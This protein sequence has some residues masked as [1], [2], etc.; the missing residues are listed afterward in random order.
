M[1]VY[2]VETL[3]FLAVNGA[4]VRAY[5]WSRE[6]FA[7]MTLRDIR[8]PEDVPALEREVGALQTKSPDRRRW[9][10]RRR[11][12]SIVHVEISAYDVAWQTTRARLVTVIDVSEQVAAE[13]EAAAARTALERTVD[14]LTESEQRYRLMV[15]GSEQVF[16]YTHDT[17]GIFEYISPS[18]EAVLG[19]SPHELIGRHYDVLSGDKSTAEEV[20]QRTDAALASGESQSPYVAYNRHRNGSTVTVELT[21]RP[22]F[23]DGAVAGIQGFARDITG[24]HQLERQL[25][26]AQKMEAVGRLA[27]GIA[28]DFN[29]ILTAI[30]G[31]AELLLEHTAPEDPVYDDV[32][33]INR[34]AERA[35]A[36]TRQLLA[37]SRKQVL[38]PRVIDLGRT[39]RGVTAML[40]RLIGEH[41]ALRTRS[42]DD[43]WAVRADPGQLEQVL[44]NL[45]MNA[46]DAMPRGGDLTVDVHN[47]DVHA[48]DPRYPGLPPG[49]Y[50]GFSVT[51]TGHGIEPADLPHIFEPFFTTK[52]E[53][54]GT[55][56]GLATVYGIVKQ[57]D[58]HI[59]VDS[60]VGRGAKFLVL[61]PRVAATP[62]PEPVQVRRSTTSSGAETILLV[63]DEE[64][65]RRLIQRVL[66]G[67]GY[68]VVEAANGPD[69]IELAR[70]H[71][72]RIHLLLTDVIMPQMSG[73]ELAQ[74]LRGERP[75][76][77]ILYMSGYSE[78]MIDQFR[79][80]RADAGFLEKPFTPFDLVRSVRT[81]LD[82]ASNRVDPRELRVERRSN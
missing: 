21:E 32:F 30:R 60:E 13:H 66:R 36:L 62:A 47:V 68:H 24:R 14:A 70:S 10:H 6:E 54:E 20:R 55:G 16:F 26:Q 8:D 41:I 64:P 78:A 57:S 56:L 65:V 50:V 2:D 72:G 1:W 19:Y 3:R 71:A 76:L 37:F 29:N 77:P 63:E 7:A 38:Q 35:T 15:E 40:E 23:R 33:E 9:R 4:A 34:G 59:Y 51:D 28:H 79:D 53:G 27:G 25:L 81:I 46:A 82:S 52:L 67:K 49:Q 58:G 12:G 43:L 61:L 80:D 31:H 22:L 75:Q 18:V 17:A 5:G 39:I 73:S 45:V 44:L 74:R 42:R 11:D 69:A 48:P